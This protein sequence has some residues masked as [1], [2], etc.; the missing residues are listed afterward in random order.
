MPNKKEKYSDIETFRK[1]RNSQKKRY[2]SKTAQCGYKHWNDSDDKL[3]LSHEISD[4]ELSKKIGHSVEAI[5][6]R[7]HKLKHNK[8]N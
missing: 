6:I 3:V 8:P 5:Q 4:S 7:R 1:V 2:Y